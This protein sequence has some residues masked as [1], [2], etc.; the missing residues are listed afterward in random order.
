[1]KDDGADWSSRTAGSV[2]IGQPRWRM[3]RQWRNSGDEEEEAQGEEERK[4]DG[5]ADVMKE[6]GLPV[7]CCCC[8][9]CYC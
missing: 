4:F 2:L 9:C 1:M 7:C 8:C 5:Q 6:D 3:R